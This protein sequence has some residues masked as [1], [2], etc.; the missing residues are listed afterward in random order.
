MVRARALSMISAVALTAGG[1]VALANSAIG[2]SPTPPPAVSTHGRAH[3]VA[4][5]SS[6]MVACPDIGATGTAVSEAGTAAHLFTRTTSDAVT[7]RVYRLAGTVIGCGTV[8]TPVNSAPSMLSCNGGTISIEMSDDT[9]VGQ[10]DLGQPFVSPLATGSSGST[11]VPA[12]DPLPT[13]PNAGTEPLSISTGTFGVLEGDPVWWL[14][15]QLGPD[16]ASAKVTFADGSTDQMA[17]VDAVAVLAHHIAVTATSDPA[18]VRGTVEL[19]DGSG[20]LLRTITLPQPVVAEPGPIPVPQP[21]PYLPAPGWSGQGP[22]PLSAPSAGSGSG[23]GAGSGSAVSPG[24][25]AIGTSSPTTSAPATA[26]SS[27]SAVIACP[28]LGVSSVPPAL[29]SPGAASSK[30]ETH[31]GIATPV[32]S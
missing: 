2:A 22:R 16:V 25:G 1:G 32:V 13:T 10:G 31:V 4:T 5:G 7:I 27:A 17:P 26:S 23:S 3:P 15:L 14:A 30:S 20:N 28:M 18:D 21:G 8:P 24:I 9:A 29:S 6:A 19:L 11:S 12:P